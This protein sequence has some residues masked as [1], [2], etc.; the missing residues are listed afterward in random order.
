MNNRILT[1][2]KQAEH[3]LTL[4]KAALEKVKSFEN[5]ILGNVSHEL[6]TPL[7]VYVWLCTEHTPNGRK[8]RL[9]RQV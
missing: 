6:K 2:A 3:Q 7:T 1:E 5:R 8:S 9:D 4:E